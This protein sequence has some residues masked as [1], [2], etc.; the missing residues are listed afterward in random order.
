MHAR[1]FQLRCRWCKRSF[2]ASRAD[3]L[4]CQ[5]ACRTAHR[6]ARMRWRAL[7][8]AARRGREIGRAFLA[9]EQAAQQQGERLH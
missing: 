3:A 6:R 5:D 7:L 4:T 9:A 8:A 2:E 1:K